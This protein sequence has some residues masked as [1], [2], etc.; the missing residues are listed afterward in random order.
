MTS[1]HREILERLQEARQD[2][3]TIEKNKRFLKE[4][5]KE[6]D[7]E[8]EPAGVDAVSEATA[9][10]QNKRSALKHFMKQSRVLRFREKMQNVKLWR[11]SAIAFAAENESLLEIPPSAEEAIEEVDLETIA[12]VEK[13]LETKQWNDDVSQQ[14]LSD[15][16]KD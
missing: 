6:K 7:K 5:S 14:K 1:S 9:K 11:N 16:D 3:V 13:A 4:S 15:M 8:E 2:L 12:Q 10:D